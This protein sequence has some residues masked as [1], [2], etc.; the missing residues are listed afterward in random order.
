MSDL[1]GFPERLRALILDGN[2]THELVSRWMG[3]ERAAVSQWIAGRS[4]PAGKGQDSRSD[5]I[6]HLSKF[7]GVSPEWLY[8]G[9][10]KRPAKDAVARAVHDAIAELARP[11]A[12]TLDVAPSPTLPA[13]AS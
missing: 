7:F 9:R 12:D 10:G 3:V 2:A 1:D 13:V 8:F 4:E 5:A 6:V 11:S